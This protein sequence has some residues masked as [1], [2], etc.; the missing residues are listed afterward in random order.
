MRID[1]DKSALDTNALAG[2]NVREDWL[3]QALINKQ[4]EMALL[5]L[6]VSARN[7]CPKRARSALGI[8][9]DILARKRARA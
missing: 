5:Y 9:S 4:V 6:C 3:P 1:L 7:R 8:P 2:I